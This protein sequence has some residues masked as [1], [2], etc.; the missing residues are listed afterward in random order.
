[1]A[2]LKLKSVFPVH[3]FASLCLVVVIVSRQ[4]A[5][6]ADL[7]AFVSVGGA[8]GRQAQVVQGARAGAMRWLGQQGLAMNHPMDEHAPQ[9]DLLIIIPRTQHPPSG[10][11]ICDES[12]V[13]GYLRPQEVI[14]M[15][16]KQPVCH[17]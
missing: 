16:Q 9:E 1:M 7:H 8:V 12:G 2:A 15:S 6:S 17:G 3:Q 11:G 5:V 13:A 14:R 4:G 10:D